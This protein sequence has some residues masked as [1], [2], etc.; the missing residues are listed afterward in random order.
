MTE[1]LHLSSTASLP[2]SARRRQPTT[3]NEYSQPSTNVRVPLFMSHFSISDLLSGRVLAGT[4]VT[5][6][7]WVR[8]RRDSK[9]GLSFVH[10]SD[11]S[12]F[13]PM[14]AVVR[15]ELPNYQDELLR[16][17]T[18]CS[19]IVKGELK[20]SEGKG[21]RFEVL[22]DSVEVVGWIEDPETYPLSPKQHSFEHLRKYAHLRPRSN[23]FGAIARLRHSLSF[24]IH[25]YF[26][27]NG[28]LWIHTPIITGSDAEGAGQSFAVTSQ[29]LHHP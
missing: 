20:E 18:G 17:T 25:R 13:D 14:Q 29:D 7:G 1:T 10:I 9:A 8:T 21:Q 26:H 27:E 12:C 24:A 15:A 6:R 5:V 22:A 23:T 11:G 4:P 19:V 16:L 2:G 3:D 28:F